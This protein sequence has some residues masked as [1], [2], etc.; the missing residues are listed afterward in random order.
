VNIFVTRMQ[1]FVHSTVCMNVLTLR[2]FEGVESVDGPN[3]LWIKAG[4]CCAVPILLDEIN[5]VLFWQFST[6]PKVTVLQTI[7]TMK[8]RSI[9][10]NVSFLVTICIL[11]LENYAQFEP[12]L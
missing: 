1:Y 12:H 5:S 8:G 6:Q 4:K 9:T 11:I 3:E 2:D 10:L 7:R